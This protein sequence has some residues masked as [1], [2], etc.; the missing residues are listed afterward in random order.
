MK[1]YSSELHRKENLSFARYK[2]AHSHRRT[3]DDLQSTKRNLYSRFTISDSPFSRVRATERT[4][5]AAA[6]CSG[7]PICPKADRRGVAWRSRGGKLV[8]SFGRAAQIVRRWRHLRKGL[9]QRPPR[10]TIIATEKSPFPAYERS[11]V[12]RGW[13]R[14]LSLRSPVLF[15]G[16]D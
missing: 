9:R 10:I 3:F 7:A 1:R 8:F 16:D 15:R 11:A 12:P 5:G 2:Y 14:S 4:R 6:W 13:G